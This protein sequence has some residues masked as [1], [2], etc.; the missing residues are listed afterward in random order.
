MSILASLPAR[1]VPPDALRRKLI[2]IR[3]AESIGKGAFISGSIVY[4]TLHVGL[5]AQQVGLG[6]SAAGMSGLI[7]SIVFGLIADRMGRRKLL[8]ILF[9]AL[10]VGFALY[11]VVDNVTTFFVIVVC[12]GFI[13]YGT[14]PTNSAL[15]GTMVPPNER[16]RLKALMR[17]VFNI[18]FSIGIGIAAVAALSQKLLV[19]IPLTTAALMIVAAVLVTRLP[20]GERKAIPSGFRRFAAVRDLK[21]LGVIG[22]SAVLGSHVTIVLVTL[23]LWALTRTS[24]PHA[25]VPL[26]LIFNTIFV[27]LFQVRASKGNDT[28]EGAS[29]C[30]QRSGLWLATGCL[31]AGLTALDGNVV[32]ATGALVAAMLILSIAEIMQSAS[33]WGLA[34]GL[35]PEHAQ[36]EYLGAFDLHVITQNIIGPAIISGIVMAYGFW[37][38]LTIAVVVLAA[39]AM[40]VPASRRRELVSVGVS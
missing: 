5:T 33:A 19:A 32:L 31:L 18:G 11:S 12:V 27:I 1:I 23:P 14:S 37:G 7:S 35:A 20:E 15:I 16:V 21:F 8:T 9:L 30:A 25:L 36:G 6:L 3:L 13:E 40:I 26:L 2:A 10:A 39:S 29:R 28:V 22:V 4:F 17:S 34:F 38:W 24:V